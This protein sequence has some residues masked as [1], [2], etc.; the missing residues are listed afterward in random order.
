MSKQRIEISLDTDCPEQA[1][2]YQLLR[3]A[4]THRSVAAVAK[5]V[6]MVFTPA[7][8][9]EDFNLARRQQR[10]I[11]ALARSKSSNIFEAAE[12]TAPTESSDFSPIQGF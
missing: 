4:A 6:L 7:A 3:S 12:S 11:D 5:E 9:F 1:H 10:A 2:I 8:M